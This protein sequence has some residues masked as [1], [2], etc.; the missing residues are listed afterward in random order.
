LDKHFGARP[1]SEIA[2][3]D[4]QAWAD[5]LVNPKRAPLTVN[6]TWCSAARTVFA[7]GVKTRKLSNNPFK[8]VRVTQPRKVRTR[9]TAEFTA[10]EA[11]KILKAA[12]AVGDVPNGTF[13]AAKRWVPWLC[14]YTG[15]RAGEITEL[16]GKDVV[17]QEGIWAIRI[18]PDAGSVKD[19]Q[20]RTVPLHAHLLEQG[21]LEF[22][23]SKG[24]GPLFYNQES[25]SPLRATKNERTNP[26]RARSV[27][28]VDRL[29]E[30]VRKIGVTDKA[31]RPNHAW[32]HTFKRRAARA[33]IE[34]DVR[35]AIC[36]HSPRTVADIYETPA[37][38]DMADALRHFSRYEVH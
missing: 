15:A 13:G 8:V 21:F 36:G 1:A 32:R 11:A 28:T 38:A 14:A 7:W 35:D 31:I 5:A 37:L 3:E 2:T 24:E 16:R 33:K 23:R 26:V 10:Q 34:V 9:E 30:W 27:K 22:V 17:Q 29:A 12:L 25:L 19:R 6:D 4:A 18:T 20:P